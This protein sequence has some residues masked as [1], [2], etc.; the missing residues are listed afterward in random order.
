[1]GSIP[2]WGTCLGCEFSTHSGYIQEATNLC[3]SS[4]SVFLSLSLSLPS[5]HSRINKHVL[6]NIFKKY[7]IA[8]NC[9]HHLSLQQ[10]IIIVLVDGLTSLLIAT[11]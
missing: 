2:N 10:V 8:K 5:P 7:F 3:F 9:N 6:Q 1:M 4:T 11:D